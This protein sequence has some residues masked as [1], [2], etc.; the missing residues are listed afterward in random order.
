MPALL[1][2][3]ARPGADAR[4]DSHRYPWTSAPDRRSQALRP[5]RQSLSRVSPAAAAF[6]CTR[7]T[8]SSTV[9]RERRLRAPAGRREVGRAPRGED[10]AHHRHH[11][12]GRRLPHGAAAGKGYR[13]HGM[14]RPTS[15]V[16]GTRLGELMDRTVAGRAHRPAQRRA[17]RLHQPR[18]SDGQD[19]PRRGVPPRRPEPHPDQLRPARVHRRDHGARHAAHPRGHPQARQGGAV[20][21]GGHLRALRRARGGAA[22]GAHAAAAG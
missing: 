8:G 2:A 5:Q 21:P 3:R 11:R 7:P 15:T 1:T 19:R 9:A 16:A 4:D 6:R 20:L 10:G 13:I 18:A 12:P 17:H 22:D 14:V